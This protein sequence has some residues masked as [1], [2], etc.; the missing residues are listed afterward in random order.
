MSMRNLKVRYDGKYDW[1]NDRGGDG[2]SYT[3][4]SHTVVNG[5]DLF[6]ASFTGAVVLLK[7]L[8]GEA[9]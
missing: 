5:R 7:V 4:V 6:K 9:I 1:I 2:R 8:K 3:I